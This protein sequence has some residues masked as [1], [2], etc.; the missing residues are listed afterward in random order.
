M[1]WKVGMAVVGCFEVF[2]VATLF[3]C[4]SQDQ[5]PAARCPLPAVAQSET[6]RCRVALMSGRRA[7]LFAVCRCCIV[8][9]RYSNLYRTHSRVVAHPTSFWP[10]PGLAGSQLTQLA[11]AC[12]KSLDRQ[13][14]P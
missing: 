11:T 9:R 2:R 8:I 3:R 10:V 7:P 1:S 6:S 14:A 5:R 13:L 12:G 4:A